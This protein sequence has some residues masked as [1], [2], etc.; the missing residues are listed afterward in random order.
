[1]KR[2]HVAKTKKLASLLALSWTFQVGRKDKR[3]TTKHVG[4]SLVLQVVDLPKKCIRRDRQHIGRCSSDYHNEGCVLQ[5]FSVGQCLK[6]FTHALYYRDH[7]CGVWD[8][9]L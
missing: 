3:K 1:M 4:R 5:Q 8:Y 6:V 2:E 9:G 7:A